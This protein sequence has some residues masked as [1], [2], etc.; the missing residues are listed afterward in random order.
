MVD[1]RSAVRRALELRL[2]QRVEWL[3]LVHYRKTLGGGW[4]SEADGANFFVAPDGKTNPAAELRATIEG[5]FSTQKRDLE[6]EG[7]PALSVRCQFPA[8]W[9]FLDAELGLG[10]VTPP[11]SCPEL[12]DFRARLAPKAATLV[13]SS[14]HVNNPSSAFGHSFIRIQRAAGGA[15]SERQQLLDHGINYAANPTTAN[16]LLYMIYGL[17]GG[18]HGTFSTLPYYYKVREYSDF[19]TRDLWEYEL[20]LSAEELDQLV[21][22]IWELSTTWFTYYYLSENCSYHMLTLLE[23]AVPRVELVKWVPFYVIPTDTLKAL[24]RGAGGGEPGHG[25]GFVRAVHY[26]PSLRAQFRARVDRLSEP[27]RRWLADWFARRVTDF[28]VMDFDGNGGSVEAKEVIDPV[29][30][31]RILDAYMDQIDLTHAEELL[32]KKPDIVTWK[33]KILLARS[34]LPITAPLEVE[35]PE[36]GA[37]HLGHGSGRMLF[38]VVDSRELG[39]A[40]AFS[41]RFALHD[42]ADSIAGLPSESEIEFFGLQARWWEREHALR[43]ERLAL[44][45]VGAYR[46]LRSFEKKPS[47]RVRIGAD[48]VFDARCENCLA[49]SVTGGV[50]VTVELPVWPRWTAY[51]LLEAGEQASTGFAEESLTTHVGPT[52]GFRFGWRDRIWFLTEL[53]YRKSFNKLGFEDLRWD[54]TL[55]LSLGPTWALDARMLQTRA[56]REIAAGVAYYF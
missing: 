52:F 16:P 42:L 53:Q 17:T 51:A 37:P 23:A 28:E 44:F 27:E 36:D 26:R 11:A 2:D 32:E 4:E 38:H 29:A 41:V 39:A 1:A 49:A 18:F 15:D 40:G 30:L 43:L 10:A 45:G 56:D 20:D 24:L 3:R 46:P 25:G 35:P 12:D 34:R 8:R 55:R 14:Y 13:F 48:R 50:G 9:W 22:H 6:G 33:E 7:I 47:W 21:S 19:E 54:S 5:Y 31:A